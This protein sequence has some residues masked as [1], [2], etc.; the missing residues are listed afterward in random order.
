[1]GHYLGILIVREPTVST[2]LAAV[3]NHLKNDVPINP[4]TL[5]SSFVVWQSIT[6]NNPAPKRFSPHTLKV[7]TIMTLIKLTPPNKTLKG[8]KLVLTDPR[9]LPQDALDRLHDRF[10]D[11]QVQPFRAQATDPWDGATLALGTSSNLPSLEQARKLEL[12]Q[13][14][15]AGAD[16]LAGN[17]VFDDTKISFCT[18]SGVHGYVFNPPK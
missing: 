8:H 10:P 1:M 4:P 5:Y 9:A 17:P 6:F 15:S 7:T 16:G 2:A 12:Y 14:T 18:A 13:L 3:L 11:L